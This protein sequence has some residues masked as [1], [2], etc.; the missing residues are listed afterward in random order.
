M[1]TET[2]AVAEMVTNFTHEPQ[3]IATESGREFLIYP[4]GNGSMSCQDASELNAIAS[5]LPD[6]IYQGVTLQT[7]NSLVDYVDIFKT[8]QTVLFADISSN[9]I[10]AAIDYHNPKAEREHQ[11]A[12]VTHT[13]VLTLPYSVEWQTW[14]SVDK[15]LMSQLE[16]ARFLE[17][18]AGD[19]EAPSGAD[20]LEACRDL[21]AARKVDFTRA[22][23]T[24]SE[25]E[26]FEFSDTTTAT[27]KKGDLELPTKFKLNLPVYFDGA[28]VGLFAFLRWKLEDTNLLLGIQL[29]RAEHVRQAVFK[30]IVDEVSGRTERPAVFGKLHS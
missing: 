9:S 17:E 26:T 8:D 13:A 18:N 24:S 2:E 27:S 4:D 3:I 7:V 16:F 25:N 20:L 21:Q 1:P 12:G 28:N 6:R 5:S 10:T 23:R 30:G 29:H 22:V 19:I 15:R 14:T 11:A